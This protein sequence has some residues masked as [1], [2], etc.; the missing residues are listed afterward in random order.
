MHIALALKS[1]DAFF[2]D[3]RVRDKMARR[4]S[5]FLPVLLSFQV[6]LVPRTRRAEQA[7]MCYLLLESYFLVWLDRSGNIIHVLAFVGKLRFR[8]WIGRSVVAN[9]HG[10]EQLSVFFGTDGNKKYQ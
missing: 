4:R 5:T 2:D 6:C 3:L 8:R 7:S 1:R 9:G 10:R